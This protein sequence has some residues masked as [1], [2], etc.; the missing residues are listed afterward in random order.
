MDDSGQL[1][2]SQALSPNNMIDSVG[3]GDAFSAATI[4]GIMHNRRLDQLLPTAVQFAAK[5]CTMKGAIPATR[6]Y[7]QS[8]T[9]DALISDPR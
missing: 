1:L 5:T 6:E 7:Y 2:F 9:S 8:F 4:H 3:A